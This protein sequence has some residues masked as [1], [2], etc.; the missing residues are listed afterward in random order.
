MTKIK[1]IKSTMFNFRIRPNEMEKIRQ[2]A[3]KLN[4]VSYAEFIRQA[5]R[6]KIE[7][8]LKNG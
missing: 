5:I 2:A 4:Y 3:F 1:E 7:S 8:E 6:D